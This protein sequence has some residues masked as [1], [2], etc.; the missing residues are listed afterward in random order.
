M[1]LDHDADSRWMV[2]LVKLY[3]GHGA[4]STVGL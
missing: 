1:V 4:E 2:H 3:E